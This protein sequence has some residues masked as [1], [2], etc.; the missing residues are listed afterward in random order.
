MSSKCLPSWGWHTYAHTHT[1]THTCWNIN[2]LHTQS[3][4][5]FWGLAF[6]PADP[7]HPCFALFPFSLPLFPPLPLLRHWSDRMVWLADYIC[8]R[9]ITGL[10][11]APTVAYLFLFSKL[12]CFLQTLAL[13]FG[14]CSPVHPIYLIKRLVESHPLNLLQSNLVSLSSNTICSWNIC[15]VC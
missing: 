3:F 12:K 4:A 8:K 14:S 1:R 2:A 15:A 13:Y 10:H 6:L 7:F 5:C 11:H 9:F